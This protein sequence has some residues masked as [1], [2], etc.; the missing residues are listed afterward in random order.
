MA[1]GRV[2]QHIEVERDG[3]VFCVCVREQR[4]DDNTVRAMAEEVDA[5]I[6]DEG[7]RKLV[8]RLGPLNCIYSV[9]IA[10][11]IKLRR[12]LAERGGRLRLCEV[13]PQVMNVF[14]SCQLQD[15]FEFSPDVV[16]AVQALKKS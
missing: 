4:P 2:Y 13:S 16:S 8:F 10:R 6:A 14:E 5:L 11:L 7:C 9:L 15:Y 12:S 1:M 3:D